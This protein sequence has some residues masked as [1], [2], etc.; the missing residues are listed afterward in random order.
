MNEYNPPMLLPNGHVYGE[1]VSNTG[2]SGVCRLVNRFDIEEWIIF[3]GRCC[4]SVAVF[5]FFRLL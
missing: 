5:P 3:A 2:C 4:L 1:Q